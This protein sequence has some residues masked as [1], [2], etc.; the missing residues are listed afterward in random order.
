MSNPVDEVTTTGAF[1][2]ATGDVEGD[3]AVGS[4]DRVCIEGQSEQSEYEHDHFSQLSRISLNEIDDMEKYTDD[5]LPHPQGE[6][7][8]EIPLNSDVSDVR[9]TCPVCEEVT[10]VRVFY[11]FLENELFEAPCCGT[12]FNLNPDVSFLSFSVAGGVSPRR[13]QFER[14]MAELDAKG[15]VNGN[16]WSSGNLDKRNDLFR[17]QGETV[18]F[19]DGLKSPISLRS[20]PSNRHRSLARL[21]NM[22]FYVMLSL[23]S[24]SSYPGAMGVGADSSIASLFLAT[25]LLLTAGTLLYDVYTIREEIEESE[26]NISITDV[27]ALSPTKLEPVS[28]RAVT[29][30]VSGL[31]PQS[32][33]RLLFRFE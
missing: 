11:P 24:V 9:F 22:D 16:P 27:V 4:D 25:G 33:K 5:T 3:G 31:L 19:V 13:M 8:H 28:F 15:N 17:R 1:H 26:Y 6:N 7:A 21:H 29:S 32:L 23:L 18:A 10:E 30:V 14:L 2:D 20:P 12:S